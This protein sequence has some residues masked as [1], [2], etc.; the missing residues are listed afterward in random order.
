MEAENSKTCPKDCTS[1][2]WSYVS[3]FRCVGDCSTH[4]A[5]PRHQGAKGRDHHQ[6]H[7]LPT[8]LLKLMLRCLQVWGS[9]LVEPKLYHRTIVIVWLIHTNTKEQKT[10]VCDSVQQANTSEVWI[11]CVAQLLNIQSHYRQDFQPTTKKANQQNCLSNLPGCA[12]WGW[13]TL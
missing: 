9:Y 7:N 8:N 10:G 6:Q 12:L 2:Q 13:G 11:I 5:I 4:V 1:L 3:S